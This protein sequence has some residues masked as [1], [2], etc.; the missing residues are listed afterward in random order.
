MSAC[1]TNTDSSILMFLYNLFKP[2]IN[3]SSKI[4]KIKL[5]IDMIL[6]LN[7]IM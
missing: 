3:F 4:I 6:S 2:L 7:F 1:T 5:N